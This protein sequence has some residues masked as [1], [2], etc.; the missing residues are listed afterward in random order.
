MFPI[1]HCI[2][3]RPAMRHRKAAFAGPRFMSAIT[4]DIEAP[5]A[6]LKPELRLSFRQSL[7]ALSANLATAGVDRVKAWANADGTDAARLSAAMVLTDTAVRM[8]VDYVRARQRG[9]TAELKRIDA[10]LDKLLG[11]RVPGRHRD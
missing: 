11:P 5:L 10:R 6:L 4:A 2:E 7:E 8:F 1:K 9:N 3:P